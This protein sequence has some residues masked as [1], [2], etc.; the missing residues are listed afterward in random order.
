M[1]HSGTTAALICL[2]SSS[3]R[4]RTLAASIGK[5]A[6]AALRKADKSSGTKVA[7]RRGKAAQQ[8]PSDPQKRLLT[9][10]RV[11]C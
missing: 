4:R 10:P 11:L 7:R 3:E 6:R 2:H 1:G 5:A 8:V 9:V